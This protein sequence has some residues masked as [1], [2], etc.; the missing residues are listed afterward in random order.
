MIVFTPINAGFNLPLIIVWILLAR[1]F[2]SKYM[3]RLQ[4]SAQ[5]KFG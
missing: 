4:R 2:V 1:C 5:K 3:F